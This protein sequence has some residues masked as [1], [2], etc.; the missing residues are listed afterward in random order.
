[1]VEAMAHGV[2]V[3]ISA[4]VGI[5]NDIAEASAGRVVSCAVEPLAETMRQLMDDPEGLARMSANGRRLALERYSPDLVARQLV[6]EYEVAMR[7]ATSALAG[8]R[9]AGEREIV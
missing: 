3:L 8:R 6:A 2:P 4:N 7:R 1:M 5:H 9:R